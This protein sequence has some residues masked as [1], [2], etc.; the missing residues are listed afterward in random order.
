MFYKMAEEAV[1]MPVAEEEFITIPRNMLDN[2]SC[3]IRMLME[4]NQTTR[5][6]EGSNFHLSLILSYFQMENRQEEVIIRIQLENGIRYRARCRS[7]RNDK[8]IATRM[9]QFGDSI[10]IEIIF[11]RI[12]NE[13]ALLALHS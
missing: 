12:G 1:A 11:C 6:N 10:P 5:W 13:E 3:Y 7:N 2:Y 8:I 9:G 4:E